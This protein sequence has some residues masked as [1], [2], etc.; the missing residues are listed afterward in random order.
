MIM[1]RFCLIM[2][3]YS[4]VFFSHYKKKLLKEKKKRRK[5]RLIKIEKS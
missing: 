2:K 1:N 3:R 4:G 5:K